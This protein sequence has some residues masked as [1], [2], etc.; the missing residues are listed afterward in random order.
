MGAFHGVEMSYVFGIIA[1]PTADDAAL[2]VA[3]R[4]YWTRFARSGNPNRPNRPGDRPLLKW[5]RYTEATDLRFEFDV[6]P[7]IIPGFRRAQ[8]ELWWSIYDEQFD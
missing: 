2:G 3:V 6:K 7:S 4:K 1:P 5:P 8:C